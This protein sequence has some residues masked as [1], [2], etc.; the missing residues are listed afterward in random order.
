MGS[1][2]IVFF[3]FVRNLEIQPNSIL[4]QICDQ[5]H[6]FLKDFQRNLLSF[7]KIESIFETKWSN[8]NFLGRKTVESRDL[9]WKSW[10]NLVLDETSRN[11][12][13]L[14]KTSAYRNSKEND[15]KIPIKTSN[16]HSNYLIELSVLLITQNKV[17]LFTWKL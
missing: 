1:L 9:E 11:F 4:K 15:Q 13:F 16:N 17:L 2:E 3:Q 14:F 8:F 7:A 6:E 5:S 12:R 10:T